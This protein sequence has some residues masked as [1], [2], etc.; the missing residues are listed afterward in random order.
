MR[1]ISWM[2]PMWFADR[3]V[4]SRLRGLSESTKPIKLADEKAIQPDAV[5]R[6]AREV[7]AS[8]L[9]C[10]HAH[11]VRDETLGEG[12]DPPEMDRRGGLGVGA[13]P[14]PDRKG[15]EPGAGLVGYHRRPM[16]LDP[17]TR[18]P[19]LHGDPLM[20]IA[21]DGPAGLRQEHARPRPRSAAGA[22]LPGHRGHVSRRDLG[23]PRPGPRAL[24]WGGMYPPW[25]ER[26]PSGSTPRDRC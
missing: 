23:C 21:I 6:V 3:R 20:I 17:T 26:C 7:G 4:G 18:P 13:G 19:P 2:A 25:P 15:G 12:G 9:A 10:G 22:H 1:L 5:R 14:A 16:T 24:G 11:D 8:A